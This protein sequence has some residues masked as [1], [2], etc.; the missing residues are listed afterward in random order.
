MNYGAISQGGDALI[1][2]WI[3]EQLLDFGLKT[4]F[5]TNELLLHE[6]YGFIGETTSMPIFSTFY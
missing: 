1:N 3:I 6:I 2:S 5:R 4:C